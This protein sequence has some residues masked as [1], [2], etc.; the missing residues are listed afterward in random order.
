[1]SGKPYS[2]PNSAT[3]ISLWF[4]AL[5]GTITLPFLV[6]VTLFGGLC[7]SMFWIL[8]RTCSWSRARRVLATLIFGGILSSFAVPQYVAEW[9]ADHHTLAVKSNIL[10]APFVEGQ[11][12]A[13][14]RWKKE[15][16]NVWL[17]IDSGTLPIQ[18]LDFVVRLDTSIAAVGQVT[19]FPGVTISPQSPVQ[20]A[21]L[22]V[23]GPDGQESLIPAT[24]SVISPAYRVQCSN[25]FAKTVIS[26]SIASLALIPTGV[27]GPLLFERR[28]PRTMTITGEYEIR[29]GNK[30]TIRRID[31]SRS[32]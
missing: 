25:L 16:V 27:A 1:M 17:D 18:N 13:G 22:I 7:I 12:F 20:S 10:P 31:L 32:F 4:A 5:L 29:Q 24:G 19:A 2:T 23:V 30:A 28:P 6:R 14:F 26:F 21:G 15:Y 3:I 8:G 11:G 9:R